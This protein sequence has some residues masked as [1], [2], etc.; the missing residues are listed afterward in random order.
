[1]EKKRK[2]FLVREVSADLD[3]SV[4]TLYKMIRAGKLKS[5]TKLLK[6]RDIKVIPTEEVEML[7]A[8]SIW[9]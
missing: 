4:T 2:Y 1:M 8:R 5:E 3:V 7:R 9:N 6:G